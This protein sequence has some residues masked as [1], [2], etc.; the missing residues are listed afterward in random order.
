MLTASP[1][2]TV[3]E[4]CCGGI[5]QTVTTGTQ[6]LASSNYVA[7]TDEALCNE[8]G[9]CVDACPFELRSLEVDA[10]TDW[11]KCLGCGVRVDKCP[12]EVISLVRDEKKGIPLEPKTLVRG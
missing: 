12:E 5:E 11:E 4:Y 7:V 2:I 10:R 1:K 9:T 3:C 6:F 8:C